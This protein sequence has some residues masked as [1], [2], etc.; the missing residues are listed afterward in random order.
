VGDV[1]LASGHSL[2]VLGCCI[3][4]WSPSQVIV[5]RMPCARC[6]GAWV[7]AADPGS[8]S[9]VS[10]FPGGETRSSCKVPEW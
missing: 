8:L 7:G 10:L 5:C 3:S 9:L 4:S 1:R 2:Q 6:H